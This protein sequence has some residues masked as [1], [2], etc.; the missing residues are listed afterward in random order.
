[1]LL[2]RAQWHRA[3]RPPVLS[4]RAAQWGHTKLELNGQANFGC[5][6]W[7]VSWSVTGTVL[8]VTD[9]NRRV[10][11]WT[12]VIARQ[13]AFARAM[14]D[15]QM[16]EMRMIGRRCHWARQRDRTFAACRGR[17]GCGRCSRPKTHEGVPMPLWL[18]NA[19]AVES[20][21]CLSSSLARQ[22]RSRCWRWSAVVSPRKCRHFCP[23]LRHGHLKLRS[24]QAPLAPLGT[25]RAAASV[26]TL[27]WGRAPRSPPPNG[28]AAEFVTS[29]N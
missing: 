23:R 8:A 27:T 3:G 15:L 2:S 5:A 21:A 14:R 10:T 13:Q 25:P 16:S 6:V 7:G 19:R 4:T 28:Q 1:M 20:R 12:Q 22:A 17:I 9:D 11:M 29:T 18:V 26:T 24:L